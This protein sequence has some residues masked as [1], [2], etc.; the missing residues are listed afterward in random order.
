MPLIFSLLVCIGLS[1]QAHLSKVKLVIGKKK[2][3]LIEVEEEKSDK[4]KLDKM[5]VTAVECQSSH[6]EFQRLSS[7]SLDS[8]ILILF[9]WDPSAEVCFSVFYE[10]QHTFAK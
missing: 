7:T 10:D 1:G 6:L 3:K 2:F 4:E 5:H 8:P 9:H